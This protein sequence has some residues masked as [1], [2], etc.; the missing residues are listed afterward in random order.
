M[1]I[2]AYVGL[3]GAGKSFS[4]VQNVIIPALKAGRNVVT[5]IPLNLEVIASKG[6]PGKVR[7]LDKKC[8]T[9]DWLEA[10]HGSVVVIDEVWNWWPAGTTADAIPA[11]QKSFFAEHRH[12]VGSDGYATEIVLVTQDLSQIAAFLRQLVA[13]TFR[14]VKLTAIGSK[15][16]FRVDVYNGAVTGQ[17]PPK[18]QFIR[19][20]FGKYDPEVY[21]LYSSHTMSKTG[22]AGLEEKIDKRGT[23]FGSW[24]VKAA[25]AALL[26]IP[27]AIWGVVSS[28]Q[29]FKDG[30]SKGRGS[31][32]S[33]PPA[34]VTPV[35]GSYRPTM[36]E[37]APVPAAA[38]ATAPEPEP[39]KEPQL[40]ARWRILGVAT[41]PDGSGIALLRSSTA[42]RRVDLSSCKMIGSDLDLKCELD[43]ELVTYYSGDTGGF[44]SAAVTPTAL[45]AQ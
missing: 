22:V 26:A 34:P 2:P 39:P 33:E 31:E 44:A 45:A 13:E 6:W 11:S 15:N 18:G 5:N 43:G 10:P 12:R 20:L 36:P 37:P 27:L 16:R 41:K 40:S 30:V 4:T 35:P 14:V 17:T 29:S 7:Q 8:P 1:S 28:L 24:Q 19:S 9:G 25:G 21:A 3:P 23:V 32:R 42:A 38:V